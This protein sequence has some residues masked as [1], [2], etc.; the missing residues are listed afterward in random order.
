M[1]FLVRVHDPKRGFVR[2]QTSCDSCTAVSWIHLQEDSDGRFSLGVDLGWYLRAEP[3]I[4]Q[5]A[6]DVPLIEVKCPKHSPLH[7]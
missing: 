7:H 2:P 4:G 5:S 3:Q 1:K 6:A